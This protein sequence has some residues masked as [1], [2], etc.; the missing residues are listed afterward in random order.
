LV[1]A[2]SWQMVFVSLSLVFAGIALG[3]LCRSNALGLI[4]AG[5]GAVGIGA[6]VVPQPDAASFRLMLDVPVLCL[7]AALGVLV[8]FMLRRLFFRRPRRGAT[9]GRRETWEP[10][11]P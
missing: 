11:R 7:Y 9:R 2:T 5:L 10:K 8:L 1:T 6:S 4:L 3:F